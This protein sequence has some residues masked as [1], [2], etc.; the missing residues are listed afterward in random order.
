[1]LALMLALMLTGGLVACDDAGA[2]RPDAAGPDALI[3]DAAPIDATPPDAAMDA[4]TVDAAPVDM[5]VDAA[6]ADATSDAIVLDL[7][8]DDAW[9]DAVVDSHVDAAVDM[10][11]PPAG[12]LWITE[13][14]ASNDGAWVDEIGETDDWLELHNASDVPLSLAGYRIGDGP[15]QRVALPPVT[16]PPGGFLVLWADDQVGQGALHLPFKLSSGG[17]TVYLW[18]PDG[19]EVR[20]L[21]YGALATNDSWQWYPDGSMPCRWATPGRANGR[22]CGPPPPPE[23]PAVVEYADYEWSDPWPF[24]PTPLV[25]TELA[26]RPAEFIEVLNSSAAPVVLADF[27][28]RITTH[29]PGLDWP[30]REAGQAIAWPVDQ[31][32]PGERVAVPV[33]EADIAGLT[34]SPLFE[35]VVSLWTAERNFP[36][37]RV[38]FMRWPSDAYLT[39]MPDA[40]GRHRFCTPASRG[41]PNVDCAPLVARD[42]GDRLRH[43]RTPTDFDG[44]AEGGVATGIASVKVIVDTQAGDA[45]HLASAG[46]WDL[47]YTFVR[48]VIDGDPH[49]DRCDADESAEHLRGWSA[50]SR[51]NYTEVENR[52]YLLGTLV[53][54]GGADLRTLEFTSGDRIIAAQMRRAFFTIMNRVMQPQRW[55]LRP[56]SAR[57]I[58]EMR[59]IEGQ[60]PLVGPNAPFRGLTY[61]PLTETVGYGVLQFVPVDQLDSVPLGAEVIVVTDQV[62]N[63]IPLTGGLITE[64][65]QTPLAHVNL[66]S[67]NRNT[68][69]MALRDA[70]VDPRVAPLLGQLVRLN[71]RG[72]GFDL[73]AADPAEALAFW[74]SRRPE[75]PPLEPRLD[76]ALRGVTSLGARGLIDLPR[77]GAKAAQLAELAQVRS[78]RQACPGPVF[79]PFRPMAIPVVH[80]LEHYAASGSAAL[81][82]QWEARPDFG[83][84]GVRRQALAEVRALVLAHPV[85]PALLAEVEAYMAEHYGDA[86]TRLRSSSNT[87]DLPGFNG[88]GLYTSISAQLGDDDRRVDDAIRVVWASLYNARAYDERNYFNIARDGVAMGILV[89]PAFLSERANAVAISRN[90]IEPIRD[91]AYIN[92]QKG[93]ATVTNPAPGVST[94]QM[95]YRYRRSPRLVR[96]GDSSLTEDRV[97]SDDE[98]AN[99]ACVLKAIHDHF[100]PLIDPEGETQW[101]AMDIEFKLLGAARVLMVKQARPY[102]F[103]AREVPADCREL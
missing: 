19:T 76:T 83:D 35:G 43:L 54:H 47:H 71:V 10:A 23:V 16:I 7:G 78:N 17:E 13:I 61:Q 60:A 1:M 59:Q 36:V 21:D 49:L 4:A 50:F 70:R 77:I 18:A 22:L 57:Q 44:L 72:G 66:L 24:P 58:D 63:D 8:P 103:G 91:D 93:E 87:E 73:Q 45:V 26:L 88:A 41:A 97:L 34:D 27:T 96:L 100:E 65:F 84:P 39:R 31:L 6:A 38:D 75:G 69:N 79:T 95:L 56:Q 42:V 9:V 89:H 64:A 33:A 82:A 62:P 94:E 90:V 29:A 25:I 46:A 40:T 32:L 28:L 3:V 52:R 5:R 14:M 86:R 51:A 15:G 92:V 85:E 101:F 37:D 68:P 55:S 74:E 99:A 12:P 53:H 102:S 11:L 67:R 48:E 98:I 2:L 81:L 30:D 20:A 80:S